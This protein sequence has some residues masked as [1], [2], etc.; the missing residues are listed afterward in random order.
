MQNVL[1]IAQKLLSLYVFVSLDFIAAKVLNVRKEMLAPLV[2][3]LLTPILFFQGVMDTPLSGGRIFLPL[4]IFVLASSFAVATYVFGR[5]IFK[6]PALNILAFSAGNANSGYFGFP[7]AY[8]L[9]GEDGLGLAVLVA[10][11][12]VIYENSVGFYL[13]ARGRHSAREALRRLFRLPALYAFALALL[14]KGVQVVPPVW[15]H[16]MAGIVRGAYTVL[17]MMIVGMGMADI[18][19]SHFD[20]R[21]V[22][23]SI[24]MK[25]LVWPLAMIAF[26]TLEESVWGGFDMAS[27]R[28][29]FLVSIVPL[30]ANT[31]AFATLLKAEPEKSALAVLLSTLLALLAI[32]LWLTF[33]AGLAL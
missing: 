22:S 8:L 6:K 16:D 18:R 15:M 29:L 32:P 27:R 23:F 19:R 25:Y 12:F 11:G 3:Y 21:F 7:L 1:F 17:G 14:L 13:V 31:V 28:A 5:V 30:A 4:V 9:Y 26:L 24:G 10:L 2:I 33:K 20:F